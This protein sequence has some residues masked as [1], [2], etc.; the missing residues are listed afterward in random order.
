MSGFICFLL[1]L[2][3]FT[4]FSQEKNYYDG[5]YKTYEEIKMRYVTHE[6]YNFYYKIKLPSWFKEIETHS[7]YHFKGSLPESKGKDEITITSFGKEDFNSFEEFEKYIAGNLEFGKT[8]AWGDS[9]YKCMD[10][11]S[12]GKYKNIG[13]SYKVTMF[14]NNKEYI[15]QYVL[16]ESKTGCL[17]IDF[18]STAENFTKNLSLFEEFLNGFSLSE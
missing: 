9:L 15:H 1:I 13:P 7:A 14:Y 11:I 18:K 6:D 2:F 17:W 8:P 4:A 5:E 3:S 10:K 16:C 12:L